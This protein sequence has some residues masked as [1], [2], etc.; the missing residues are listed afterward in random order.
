MTDTLLGSLVRTN[1]LDRGYIP[2]HYLSVISAPYR[3]CD[4]SVCLG[5]RR[6]RDEFIY[7]C[8]MAGFSNIVLARIFG[9]SRAHVS[10]LFGNVNRNE[11]YFNLRPLGHDAA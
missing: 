5:L 6:N 2:R 11:G 3:S 4:C 8:G 9:L 10:R 1:R 7:S